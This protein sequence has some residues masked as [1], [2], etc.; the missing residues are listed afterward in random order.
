[1][2]PLSSQPLTCGEV[3][4]IFLLLPLL[5]LL[6]LSF[7]PLLPSSSTLFSSSSSHTFTPFQQQQRQQQYFPSQHTSRTNSF[8]SPPVSHAQTH[9]NVT[10]G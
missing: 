2:Y 6:S 5:S 3:L 9:H 1:M 4:I 10:R 8:L 7:L